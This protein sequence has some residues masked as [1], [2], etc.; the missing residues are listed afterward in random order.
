MQNWA[1]AVIE[2]AVGGGKN[3]PPL[4]FSPITLR[5]VTARNRVMISPMCQYRSVDG[6]PNDWHL[7]HLGKFAMGGAGIIFGEE[8]AIEAGGRK[9]HA[10]AGI[11]HSDHIR[12]YRRINKFLKTL[13]AVSGIQLGHSGRKAS[14]H[15]ASRN[16]Q[17]LTKADTAAGLPP[18]TAIAPSPVSEAPGGPLP[19]EMDLGDIGRNIEH[20]VRATRMA[21]DADFDICEIHGAHGYLI[22]QFLSPI[23]NRRNS[24][25]VAAIR[26][27]CSRCCSRSSLGRPAVSRPNTR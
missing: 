16:W 8:T 18:W 3:V 7:V 6:G 9:T 10:C 5:G 1:T 20:W 15:D 2:Q 11:Y 12:R 17:P 13:G 22:H 27:H 26:S 25:N 21:A 4:L 14:C 23:A 19:H 24:P